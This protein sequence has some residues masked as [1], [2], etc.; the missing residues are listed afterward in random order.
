MGVSNQLLSV[1]SIKIEKEKRYL[2]YEIVL[3]RVVYKFQQLNV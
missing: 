3:A 1:K 2:S